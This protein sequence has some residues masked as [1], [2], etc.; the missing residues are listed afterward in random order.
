MRHAGA[1][2]PLRVGPRN[3]ENGITGRIINDEADAMAA[4]PGVCLAIAARYG[5]G[6]KKNLPP[7]DGSRLCWRLSPVDNARA[8]RRAAELRAASA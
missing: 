7:Q 5:N 2:I 8:R 4:L 3:H 1:C 6:L